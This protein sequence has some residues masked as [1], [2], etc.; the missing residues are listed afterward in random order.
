MSMSSLVEILFLP[1]ASTVSVAVAN[2][3]LKSD[4]FM[5]GRDPRART[6]PSASTH[7]D[8]NEFSRSAVQSDFDELAE[9]A[10]AP[11]HQSEID[12]PH[13]SPLARIRVRRG[14]RRL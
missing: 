14:A 4:E 8:S 13:R 7:S 12:N 5:V 2:A 1:T 10:V 9:A 3:D 11:V 6:E